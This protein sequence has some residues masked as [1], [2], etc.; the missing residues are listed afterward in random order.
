LR[1]QGTRFRYLKAKVSITLRFFR[2]AVSASLSA[3]NHRPFTALAASYDTADVLSMGHVT[4]RAT[5]RAFAAEGLMAQH[6][7]RRGSPMKTVARGR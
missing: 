6:R 5:T 7:S 1:A 4:V 2:H 3:R